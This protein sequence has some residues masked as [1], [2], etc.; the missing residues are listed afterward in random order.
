MG[1]WVTNLRARRRHYC[2]AGDKTNQRQVW[3]VTDSTLQRARAGEEDAFREL[4]D[5][6]R[7]ELHLHIYRIVGS[8]HDAEDLLQETL[9]AAWRGLDAFEPRASVRAWLY[10]IATNRSLDA[11]RAT[12]RRPEDV[13]RVTEMPEPP[14]AA[15]RSGSSPS[16]TSCF[17]ALRTRLPARR[18]AT[19]RRGD[20]TGVCRRPAAPVGAA[21]RGAGAPRCARLPRGGGRRDARDLRALGQQPAA[22]CPC[23][24]RV[25]TAGRRTRPGAAAQLKSRARHGRPF[26]RRDPDGRHRG[27]RRSA[28]RRRL[29]HVPPE[30]SDTKDPPR[31]AVSTTAKSGGARRCWCPP[32]PTPSRHSARTSRPPRPRSP[33][34]TG[35]SSSPWKAG[36]SLR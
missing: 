18:L 25:A 27:R 11:L 20:R 2:D 33:G 10:R 4:T 6:Y 15:R 35:C 19:R 16:P 1:K 24:I 17:R 12:R 36:R 14:G 30:P 28:D 8:V 13:T 22:A 32:A 26:R 9:L 5:P 7:R 34:S 31:S 21:A 29:A 3:G 23:G